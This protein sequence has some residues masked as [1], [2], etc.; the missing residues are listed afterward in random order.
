METESGKR[1][2]VTRTGK[3]RMNQRVPAGQLS[4]GVMYVRVP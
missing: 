1:V 4:P 2:A 3:K